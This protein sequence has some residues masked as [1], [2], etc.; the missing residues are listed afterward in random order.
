M[1]LATISNQLLSVG[2]FSK[3]LA[4]K[5]NLQGPLWPSSKIFWLKHWE[6]HW[7]HIQFLLQRRQW[8]VRTTEET[9]GLHNWVGRRRL[10]FQVDC[11]VLLMTWANFNRLRWN[12]F[13]LRYAQMS[14]WHMTLTCKSSCF[15]MKCK[16][17]SG[18]AFLQPDIGSIN[19]GTDQNLVVIKSCDFKIYLIKW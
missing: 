18:S 9:K 3:K 5:T 1:Y 11:F 14:F 2:P 4:L 13:F 17:V 12:V 7:L 8:E 19:T 16:C 6:L 10:N 15:Q